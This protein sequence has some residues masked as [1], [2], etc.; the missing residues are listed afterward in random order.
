MYRESLYRRVTTALEEEEKKF[1]FE[2]S[3]PPDWYISK[4]EPVSQV[5]ISST[6]IIR[7]TFFIGFLWL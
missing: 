6:L 3:T 4:E 5:S 2:N 1:S 7:A